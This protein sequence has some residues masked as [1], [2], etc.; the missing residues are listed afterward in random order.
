[1]EYKII[2]SGSSGNAILLENGILLDCGV[3]LKMFGNQDLKKIKAVFISHEHH[4]HMNLSTLKRI[5]ELRPT[6][7][8][9]VGFWLKQYLLSAGIKNANIDIVEHNK[10]YDYGLWKIIP[11][12]L[13][14]DVKN[15]GIKIIDK[16][17]RQKIFYA[18]DTNR[19]DHITAKNYNLY[20]VEGNYDEDKIEE[21]IKRDMEQGYY[22]YGIRVKETHLSIQKTSEWL[23]ENMGNQSEYKFIHCSR[24]NL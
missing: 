6:V 15:Y 9:I 24:N 16:Q 22:S 14:H 2:K 7:R 19:I 17:K 18:V 21:N 23:M 13:I 3:P 5:H 4:D 8:F 1:M 12:I 20:L 10:V 11:V